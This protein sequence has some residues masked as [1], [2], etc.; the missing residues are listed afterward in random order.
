MV[1]DQPSAPVLRMVGI[2]KRFPGTAALTDVN[3]EIERPMIYGLVGQNGAGKSTLLKILAGE[4]GPSEGEIQIAGEAVE[5]SSSRR[6]HELGIG[7]V[8]QELSLLP[9]LSVAHNIS[10]GQEPT[11]GLR[12]DERRLLVDSRA[13]LARIGAGWINP[14]TKIRDLPLS[15][16]QLVEIAK[17]LTLRRPRILIFDEPTAALAQTDVQRLFRI[18]GSLRDEGVTVIF[19]SHRYREVLQVCERITVLRNGRVVGMLTRE[20]ASLERLVDLTLGQKAETIFQRG[21]HGERLGE[22]L[23][24]L[25]ALNVGGRVRGVDL[26]LRRGEIVG[27]CGLLGSGQNELARSI[28]GDA[29]DVGGEI[30]VKGRRVHLRSPRQALRCGVAL[31]SENRQEEGLFPDLRV[32]AN[33]SVASL[34]KVIVS[35]VLPI[36]SRRRER[37]LTRAAASAVDIAPRAVARVVRVL[38]GG[39]QQKALLARWLMRRCD[40][41]VMIE[42]TRGVDVGAKLEIY[43]QIERLAHHG[44]GVV[45]VS[46]DVPE[47]MGL[48]D[49]VL[50]LYEGRVTGEFD[51]RLAS[52]Q[53]ISLAMQGASAAAAASEP[54]EVRP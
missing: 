13:A 52:E 29:H 54:V 43:H 17:V 10:L 28:G 11:N 37:R 26:E 18:M 5:I 22:L 4:Y 25:S 14:E 41:L 8:Y 46:T 24:E 53:Q 16:R 49:R 44:A 27:I 47:V 35:R 9:N 40:I 36:L 20:E 1:T 6:A 31:I 3:L 23:L 48:A 30:T 19:V 42:P 38:S 21:L 7:T 45:V 39:N 15:E 32:A 50:T 34:A 12:I 51:P 33:I 2:S